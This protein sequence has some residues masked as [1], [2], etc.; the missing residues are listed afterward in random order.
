MTIKISTLKSKCLIILITLGFYTFS[1]AANSDTTNCMQFVNNPDLFKECQNNIKTTMTITPP[2]RPKEK[3][4]E[5]S[6][7]ICDFRHRQRIKNL[8]EKKK[9]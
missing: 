6:C 4:D 5:E 2:K 3:K 7:N 1:L 8:L 9:K